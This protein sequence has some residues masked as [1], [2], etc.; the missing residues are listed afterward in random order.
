MDSEKT[1]IICD[2]RHQCVNIPVV[3]QKAFLYPPAV[4]TAIGRGE[5]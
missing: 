3:S 5:F 1:Y 2:T 4:G